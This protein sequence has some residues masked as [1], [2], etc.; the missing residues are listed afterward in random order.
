MGKGE[1]EE[2]NITT[3]RKPGPLKNSQYSGGIINKRPLDDEKKE[4]TLV[5][6]VCIHDVIFRNVPSKGASVSFLCLPCSMYCVVHC[7][8][9]SIHG[10]K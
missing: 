1:A 2:L 5:I 8:D 6:H 7:T 3:A 4:E 9:Q 10:A